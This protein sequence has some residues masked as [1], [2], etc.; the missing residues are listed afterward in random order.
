MSRAIV[1]RQYI[2]GYGRQAPTP[3]GWEIYRVSMNQDGK[4]VDHVE[5]SVL[6]ADQWWA[7]AARYVGSGRGWHCWRRPPDSERPR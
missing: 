2:S 6:F 1:N 5:A 3:P 7:R 4:P